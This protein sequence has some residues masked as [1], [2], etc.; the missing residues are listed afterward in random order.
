MPATNLLDWLRQVCAE[1][2]FDV[3]AVYLREGMHDWP[4]TAADADDLERQLRAGGHFLPLPKEPAALANVLE[5]SLVDYVLDR[6]AEESGMEARR[7]TERGYPDIEISGET[8][9]GGFH[10][11]DVKVARRASGGRRTQSRITLYTGNT[12]F[13]YPQL[14]WP[15]TFRPFRDYASH[16][17]LIGIYTFDEASTARITDLELIVDEPW[18]IASRQRSSTTREYIGAVQSIEALR[19]GEGEFASEADFYKFWRGYQFRIGRAVQQQLDR[20]LVE[21]DRSG[22][23]T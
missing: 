7:G 23:E 12:Y 20:L 21:Q 6:A 5:V 10:A 3:L 4:I 11:V 9:G 1:Y 15:G 14:R 13:R 22:G 18:R 19:R 2:R 8:A 17:D 16:L